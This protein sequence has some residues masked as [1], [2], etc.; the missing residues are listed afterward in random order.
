MSCQRTEQ[1]TCTRSHARE[2]HDITH[3]SSTDLKANLF[4]LR[5][6]ESSY[7]DVA[8]ELDAQ[9]AASDVNSPACMRLNITD[10]T[11]RNP[12]KLF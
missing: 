5:E 4:A 11:P 6:Q 9:Q 1:S 8:K 2:E 10:N 12:F 3:I 7:D